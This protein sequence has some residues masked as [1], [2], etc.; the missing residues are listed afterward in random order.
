[1]KT[2]S[3]NIL[4][5]IKTSN[6]LKASE[7]AQKLNLDKNEVKAVLLTDLKDL[8]YQDTRYKWYF[9]QDDSSVVNNKKNVDTKLSNLCRYYLN[10]LNIEDNNS[11]SEFLSSNYS[12]KYIEL[13]NLDISSEKNIDAVNFLHKT[14]STPNKNMVT[15]VGY[16]VMVEKIF[17]SKTNKSYLKV[18]PVFLFP[19]EYNAGEINVSSIPSINK[20]VIKQYSTQNSEDNLIYEII[21]LEKQLGLDIVDNDVEL[22]D[23][24]SRLQQLRQWAWKEEI[25]P[26]SLTNETPIQDINTEGIYN[27]A[28]I[29]ATEKSPFTLGLE[30]ELS[31]LSKLDENEYKGTALYD[32]I[33]LS[34]SVGNIKEEISDNI[35]EVLPLNSEQEQAV[36]TSLSSNVTIVTGPPGTGKSQVVTDLLVNAIWKGQNVLFTSKN[37]KAVDVVESRLNN[38]STR[39]VMLRISATQNNTNIL[40]VINTLLSTTVNIQDKV[41]YENLSKIYF[42]EVNVYESLRNKKE[43]CVALRNKIDQL[44][45]RICAFRE[46][47]QK[48]YP[49]ITSK[50]ID[51]FNACFNVVSRCLYKTIKEKQNWLIK[52]FWPI[53]FKARKN[54]FINAIA[55]FN[56]MAENY[57]IKQIPENLNEVIL[58]EYS[59]EFK[60][61]I[62][63]MYSI[64]EYQDLLSTLAT[65]E[66]LENIDRKL[67]NH[68]NSLAKKS[69]ILW[70][71]WLLAR[72]INISP[73]ERQN[74]SRFVSALKL[75]QG[76][77]IGNDQKFAK[78]LTN[79][80]KLVAKFLPCWAVTSLSAK[81]RIPFS[82]AIYDVLV[83]DEASQ[84]DIASMLPLLYRTKRVVI[85]GDNKQLPHISSISKKQDVNLLQKYNVDYEWTYSSNSIFDLASIVNTPSSLVNLLDHHRSFADIIE[86]SNKEFY[87]GKLRVATDYRKLKLP[88]NEIAGVRWIDIKGKVLKP[89][90]GGAFNNAEIKQI[91][92]ELNRLVIQNDYQGSIG[93]VTP[94]RAQAD[95]IRDA[96]EKLPELK[97][98]LYAKN[99]FLV[100]TVH[101]FQG[102]ERDIIIFSSVISQNTPFGAI[103]FLKNTGNLF[104]VAITRARSILIVVGDMDYCAHCNVP[105]MEHFV[106]YT[107]TL[108]NKILPSDTTIFYPETRDY[109]AVQNIEQVSEWEK[110]LYTKLFDA[111]IATSPQYP[112]D[113]YKLD[114]AIIINDKKKLDIEVDGEMY[115]RDWNGELCYRDQLRN[116]RLFELG[117][118]VKR[119][120]V[121]Q[122]RDQLPWCIEQIRK[123][124]Q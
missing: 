66:T 9:H 96:I 79:M 8:C 110:Y 14:L 119:F 87:E 44:E 16:P 59:L 61:C 24:I 115:H 27:R 67:W 74:M 116:Q 122:I 104:N 107:N 2:T 75:Q 123:W 77:N 112:V 78:E 90:N 120:W 4:N 46:Q 60:D 56:I 49:D 95:K 71:K 37:N 124:L 118:D 34:S 109:P 12:L 35:L 21:E 33:N 57:G 83:I 17:S 42:E 81:G 31:E 70:D 29:I 84:C 82:P 15:Y 102:D 53:I 88:K 22:D 62:S 20:E 36:R 52:I 43:A 113:K 117:W 45:Q 91:I 23:L 28:I 97:N 76:K 92:E 121:Y 48:Y 98:R 68:K 73:A 41:D 10:C 101:K 54:K 93:I 18:A 47:W 63:N 50:Q 39:P 25:D 100:D 40:S 106:E 103:I 1:M 55:S 65:M 5:L 19:V 7:I 30:N 108:G 111:G 64:I 51:N 3:Q 105:Y 86:F 114:L 72:P 89:Y 85:I 32:W 80:H 99:D 6:G 26:E 69:T 94:F 58:K 11:I 13:K 38:L